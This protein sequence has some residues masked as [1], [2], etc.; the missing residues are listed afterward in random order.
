MKE[1]FSINRP[2]KAF[3]GELVDMASKKSINSQA[4]NHG[5]ADINSARNRWNFTNTMWTEIVTALSEY[6]DMKRNEGVM[7][8]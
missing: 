2:G 6:A 3:A 5:N 8:T 1:V 7:R 4:K